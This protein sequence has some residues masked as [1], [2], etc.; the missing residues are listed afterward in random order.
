MT[1]ICVFSDSHGSLAKMKE[2]VR[3]EKPDMVLHL[4]DLVSDCEEL[5]REF[6]QLDIRN[7]RGN[8]DY[9]SAVPLLLRC[10]VEGKQIFAA[11]GHAYQVKS[12]YTRICYAALEAGADI[13]LFGHTH[14]PYRDH[15]LTLDILNPGSI[16]PGYKPSYGRITIDAGTVETEIVYL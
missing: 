13:L 12:G 4:G 3:A 1:R 8:C 9:R 2:I 6:P 11:H 5:R 16:G 15:A 14:I 10:T 7:V